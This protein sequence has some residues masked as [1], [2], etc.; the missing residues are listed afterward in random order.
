MMLG[1]ELG[2][3]EAVSCISGFSKTLVNEDGLN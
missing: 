1:N 3:V 2:N